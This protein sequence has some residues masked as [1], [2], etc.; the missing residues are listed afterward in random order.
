MKK[1]I[2]DTSSE[3]PTYISLF[4]WAGWFDIWFHNAGFNCLAM[5]E[6]EKHACDTLKTNFTAEGYKRGY[7]DPMTN[8]INSEFL[9]GNMSKEERDAEFK[10]LEEAKNN[11]MPST[12]WYIEPKILNRDITTLSSKELMNICNI[13]PGDLTAII[14]W[15]PCQWFSQANQKRYIDD[16]RNHLYKEFVR[17]VWD[18]KPKTFSMENVRGLA[19]MAGWEVIRQI[20]ED[21]VD[22]WYIVSWQ[23]INCS[24]YWVPQNRVRL[25][26]M[27]NYHSDQAKHRTIKK[28]IGYG[29]LVR[30]DPK[31]KAK[32]DKELL[33]KYW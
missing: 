12:S 33:K 6:I 14:G 31:Y 4:S 2:L 11:S 16:P 32:W 15:P 23:V 19:T 3:K 7:I 8:H 21:F 5:V 20:C 25:V 10:K 26:M 29:G 9:S 24:D 27:G 13:K 30:H 22:V 1:E 28:L 18:L 17:I